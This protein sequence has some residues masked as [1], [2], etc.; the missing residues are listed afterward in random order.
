MKQ[1]KVK[2]YLANYQEEI[3][4]EPDLKLPEIEIEELQTQKISIKL[5][6]KYY[7]WIKREKISLKLNPKGEYWAIALVENNQKT[8]SLIT[9]PIKEAIPKTKKWHTKKFIAQ[10]Y[11]LYKINKEKEDKHIIVLKGIIFN[12]EGKVLFLKR[13]PKGT[14]TA[15]K[16]WDLPGGKISDYENIEKALKR[17][18][19]EETGLL[20]KDIKISKGIYVYTPKG[21]NATYATILLTAKLE[22]SK[23]A[24]I[25]LNNEHMEYKWV[26]KRDFFTLDL[27]PYIRY[28]L[29]EISLEL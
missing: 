6:E 13:D 1:I 18:V 21:K 10:N 11:L 23:R 7:I 20:I 19:F 27:A 28:P 25:L 12:H 9:V 22:H 8:P 24:K 2:V 29:K 5:Y 16:K 15:E 4:L 17:E 14:H 3:Y 26:E